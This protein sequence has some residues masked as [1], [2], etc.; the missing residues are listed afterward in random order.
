MLL[1]AWILI[2]VNANPPYPYVS[3]FSVLNHVS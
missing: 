3:C 2:K 1:V